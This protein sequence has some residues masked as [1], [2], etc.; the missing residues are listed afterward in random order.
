M[1][2]WW[3]L[4]VLGAFILSAI[5]TDA[6]RVIGARFGFVDV[7]TSER[8]KHQGVIPR[9]GGS[10]IY[11]AFSAMTLAVL[12]ISNHL[13]SGEI[14]ARQIVGFLF[15]GLILMIGGALDDKYNLPPKVT[16]IFPVLAAFTAIV[17]GLGVSKIT[18]PLGGALII[19]PVISDLL[20]FGWLMVM[21]YTTKLLDGL[22]GLA[23]GVS[24]IGA[25][26][27]ALLALS[28]K[29]FQ[30]DVALLALIAFASLIG[31]LV[32]NFCPAKIFLGEGGSTFLGYLIGGLAVISGG[33]VATALLVLGVPAFDIIFV[34]AERYRAHRSIF[35]GD[36]THLHHR[37]F[38][39]GLSQRQVVTVYYALSLM[40]GL[41]TLVFQSWQKLL[42]LAV[43][44]L[45]LMLLITAISRRATKEC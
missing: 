21:T 6:A 30:P 31:F 7:A 22:D 29:F 43:L 10:A 5:L 8:K 20:T 15:G 17:A 45:S 13:T 33:K 23:T 40:F 28:T 26:M 35:E 12:F 39:L 14:S 16:I 41:T 38:D 36:R 3:F 42:A 11:L 2:G 24:A 25:L 27:I 18:N 44:F 32:W 34:M 9:L 37:L 19:S 1:P 4:P